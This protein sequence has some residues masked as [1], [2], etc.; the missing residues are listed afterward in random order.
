MEPIRRTVEEYITEDGRSP[1]YEWFSSKRL[2]GNARGRIRLRVT[3]IE[4]K[5]NYGDCGPV[6]EGVFELRF[7]G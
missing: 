3:R 7:I 4:D 1:Y 6:G 5:G 2:D